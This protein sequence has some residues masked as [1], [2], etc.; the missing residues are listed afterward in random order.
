[1]IQE[2]EK[3]PAFKLVGD[4]GKTYTNKDFA[5]EHLVLFIYPK[6]MTPGCTQEACDFRDNVSRISR[7]K[8][9][10]VGLSKL[11][12]KSKKKFKE[13]HQLNFLLLADPDQKYLNELG[14]IK[15]K[16]MYGKKVK[17]IVRTTLLVGP[18]GKVE[19]LWSPVKIEGHVDEVLGAL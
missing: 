19:K 15:D 8:A 2:G 12:E 17:G 5:G 14:L 9:Q 11:D 13:K 6:D 1:M 3:L 18:S 4:D 16:V 7:K 10:V